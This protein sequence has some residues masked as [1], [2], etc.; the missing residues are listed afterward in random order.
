MIVTIRTQKFFKSSH[1]CCLLVQVPKTTPPTGFHR[2][3]TVPDMKTTSK[4]KDK[5]SQ[6]KQKT[7]KQLITAQLKAKDANKTGIVA[8][9]PKPPATPRAR[10][11]SAR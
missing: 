2:A 6:S 7:P 3:H 10:A 4:D 9:P 5:P 8:K 11:K 1:P